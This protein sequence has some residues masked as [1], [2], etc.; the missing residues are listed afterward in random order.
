[1]S[2]DVAV[3]QDSDVVVTSGDVEV[4][5]DFEVEVIQVPEQGPPGP[6]GPVGPAGPP[7]TVPGP[8]GNTIRYGTVDPGGGIGINGD[9]YINTTT[10]YIFGPKAGGV[11]PPGTSLIGPAGADGNTILYGAGNPLAT[12]GVNGNFYINTTTHFLFGPKAAGAWPAGTSMVGPAGAVGPIGPVGGVGPAGPEG[13]IGPE[14]PEGPI[15]P[16]GAIAEAPIDGNQYARRDAAWSIV[17]PAGGGT[18]DAGA[19]R[20]DS[21]QALTTGE[22]N[23][24]LDNIDAASQVH[25]HVKADITDFAHTHLVADITG[26]QTA[27]DG[28]AALVHTHTK[29]QITDFAHTHTKAEI[30]DFAHTHTK[31][32]IT[33]FAHTHTK[34]EITDFAHTHVGTDITRQMSIDADAGGLKLVG[35]VAAPGN[36][37]VYGT[38]TGGLRAWLTGTQITAFL[39]LFT[40]SLR[41]LVPASGGNAAHF[42]SADG[43]FKAPVA[44]L[45]ANAALLDA[46]M[47]NLSGGAV[48]AAKGLGNLVGATIT[49]EPGAR[50]IQWIANNGVGTIAPGAGVG[51]CTLLIINSGGGG[52][53]PTL[54]GWSKVEGTYEAGAN[55]TVCSVLIA[56][57]FSYLSIFPKVA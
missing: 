7:S 37:R 50:P 25:T 39:D 14:G 29:S 18:V 30:T 35:D 48:V 42:L 15:G 22:K 21:V 43:T 4:V 44:S 47:Q 49:V 34:A 1:M 8:P 56:P 5:A 31:A 51:Q 33:D 53:A 3:A 46:E 10:D 26:L 2:Y 20:F 27:L 41:G 38:G 17:A 52:P 32:E 57:W 55:Y 45:P 13:P 36:N 54:T 16:P 28:K 19:V 24:A 40:S 23:Q 9:F 12:L 11:W 6:A